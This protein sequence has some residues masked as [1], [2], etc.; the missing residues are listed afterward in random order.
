VKN[1]SKENT[2]GER[3]LPLPPPPPQLIG[4]VTTADQL[5]PIRVF[6][7]DPNDDLRGVKAFRTQ[8]ERDL[9]G[10]RD[11]YSAQIA[12]NPQSLGT[13]V[14]ELSVAPEGQVTNAAVHVT[15][16]VSHDLQ[17]AIVN[18]VKNWKFSPTQGEEVKI[19]Y[20]LLLSPEKVD[21]ATFVS[22]FKEVWPGRYR[23]L[24]ATPISV[25]AEAN[26]SALELGTIKPGLFLSVVSSQDGWL[27]ALSPKGKVG[28]LRREAISPRVEELP[29]AEPKG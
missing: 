6:G 2:G 24:G 23:V 25:R 11:A 15:G 1:G 26:D 14:L 3:P 17:Q 20:P 7:A 9:K 21:S 13:V 12:E 28:Y 18:A 29:T 8:V 5:F 22:H 27:G 10:I 19:F 16:S 4:Q